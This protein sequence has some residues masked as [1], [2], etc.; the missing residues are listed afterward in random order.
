MKH[1]IPYFIIFIILAFACPAK[2]ETLVIAKGENNHLAQVAQRIMTDIYARLGCDVSFKDRPLQRSLMEVDSGE[3]DA[4][5]ARVKGLEK[6]FPNLIRIPVPIYSIQ[7]VVFTKDKDFPVEGWKSLRAYKIGVVRGV[8]FALKGT[9]GMNRE[10]VGSL[11]SLFK[12]LDADRFDVV[13]EA[14][15]NGII[16]LKQLDLDKSIRTLSPPLVNIDLFHYVNKG[17]KH[18]VR[19]MTETLSRMTQDGSLDRLIEESE[20]QV[21]EEAGKVKLGAQQSATNASSDETE[22]PGENCPNTR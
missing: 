8:Q 18:L 17:K 22:Q 5:V 19:E 9:D 3:L 11:R 4:E 10:C 14:R 15:L 2:A 21:I 7:G 1:N 20:R 12:M 16:A 13:V 6:E